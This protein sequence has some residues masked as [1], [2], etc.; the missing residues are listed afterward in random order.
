MSEALGRATWRATVARMIPH[1]YGAAA[2]VQDALWR[3]RASASRMTRPNRVGNTTFGRPRERG[4]ASANRGP[5]MSELRGREPRPVPPVRLLRRVAR[6][7]RPA[8]G[9][10]QDG[11]DPVQ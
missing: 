7:G 3:P 9:A 5:G 10:P 11:H 6:E 4:G 2:V 1:E 8:S